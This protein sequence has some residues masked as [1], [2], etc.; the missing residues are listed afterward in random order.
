VRSSGARSWVYRFM[1]NG[2]AREM[3]LG[4]VHT[5]PLAEA[6]KRA[7]AARLSRL[8]GIDPIAARHGQRLAAVVAT[9]RTITFKECADAYLK[10]HRA[11]WKSP[12]HRRQWETTLS[13]YVFPTLAALPVSAIDVG[14]LLRVLEPIWLSK[15]ET[16]EPGARPHR[17]YSRLGGVAWLSRRAQSGA[18]EGSP[19]KPV[20]AAQPR[21]PGRA[22]R[23]A[24]L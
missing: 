11:E 9:A 23:G 4:P 22:S 16:A 17:K 18:L 1:L 19:G 24:A 7:R 14:L 2:K 3:G 21:A 12:I 8:D 15:P 6:R 10:A 20:A 5:V 13:T